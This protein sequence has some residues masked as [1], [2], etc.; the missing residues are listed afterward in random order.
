MMKNDKPVYRYIRGEIIYSHDKMATAF[1]IA[2]YY[3]IYNIYGGLACNLVIDWINDF[4]NA[5]VISEPNYYYESNMN[6]CQVWHHDIIMI[7][8]Q[9]FIDKLPLYKS[10]TG[11]WYEITIGKTQHRFVVKANTCKIISFDRLK[12]RF[13]KR[14]GD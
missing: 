6:M 9:S 7:A 13:M 10:P 5:N 12:E 11:E 1:D 8:M 4:I 2:S 14:K 3:G